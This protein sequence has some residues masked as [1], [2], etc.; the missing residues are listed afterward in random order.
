MVGAL[1]AEDL[2]E[3]FY[4]NAGL[5]SIVLKTSRFFPEEDDAKAQREVFDN[6]NLKVNEL[7]FR[8]ADIA[9]VVSAHRLAMLKASEI[10]FEKYIISST[11]PF[12][13]EDAAELGRDAP[14]VVARY[15]PDYV[16]VFEHRGWSTSR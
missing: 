5:A 7:L 2:C 8:R 9:D 1:A 4:R 13:S 14:S 16:E 15:C 3:L 12:R 10:G 6:D 11:S